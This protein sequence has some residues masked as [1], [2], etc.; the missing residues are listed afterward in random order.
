MKANGVIFDRPKGKQ[1]SYFVSNNNSNSWMISDKSPTK[2]ITVTS[3]KLSIIDKSVLTRKKQ[4]QNKTL[5]PVTPT[6]SNS[7]NTY[8]LVYWKLCYNKYRRMP[9]RFIK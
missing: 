3:P 9:G 6:F 2:T 5:T 1:K 8:I 7:R 4:Q